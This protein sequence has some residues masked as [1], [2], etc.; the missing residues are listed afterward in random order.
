MNA[1]RVA[2]PGASPEWSPDASQANYQAA[3]AAFPPAQA[4]DQ[5]AGAPGLY[6][7]PRASA[8]SGPNLYFQAPP[9][10]SSMGVPQNARVVAVKVQLS[11]CAQCRQSKVRCD[12]ARPCRKCLLRGIGDACSDPQPRKSHATSQG[13]PKAPSAGAASVAH[14]VGGGGAGKANISPA[15][16]DGVRPSDRQVA[17]AGIDASSDAR[18]TAVQGERSSVARSS[19]SEGSVL[20]PPSRLDSVARCASARGAGL[21]QT[22]GQA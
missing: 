16:V 20:S 21:A 7:A 11:A 22:D 8:P 18:S 3:A 10:P 2:L 4:Y 9:L 14:H 17:M 19:T 12:G 15:A 5:L 13:A 6:D 1:I